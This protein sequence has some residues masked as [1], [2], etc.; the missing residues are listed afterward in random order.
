VAPR[1]L[2]IGIQDFEK[3]R[4]GG[5]V[6]ADKTA[7]I[8]RLASRGQSYFLGR[9]R[10]FGKSLLVSAIK[11]YFQGKR[12]VFE[13]EPRLAIA[14]LEKEW[15]IHPVFHI[16]L[17][18]GPYRDMGSLEANLD[19][20]LRILE[21]RW[22]R[23]AGDTL[24]STRFFGLI[25]RACESFGEK[26]VVLV[27]EYDKPLLETMEDPGLNGE[28]RREL[29]GFYG[30]LKAADPWLRFVFL[31]GVTK[32]SQVSVF[33]DLNQ[34]R[35][36]SLLRDYADICG[37]TEEELRGN[38][39]PELHSLA[40]ENG[41]SFGEALDKMRKYYNGYHFCEQT[42]GVYNPFS[43]LN[44]LDSR[45]FNYYWFQTGTPTFL[46]NLLTKANF[47]L[48]R[49]S[50][51]AAIPRTAI[52][53]A[54]EGSPLSILYQSGYLTI[55][56]YDAE[57]GLY[58]L[59]FPNEEVEYG[60]LGALLPYYGPRPE[61]QDFFAGNFYTDLR[62]GDTDAFMARLGAFFS[63]IPYDLH[64]RTER[65]YQTVFYLVFR[66]LGQFARAEVRSAAGRSDAVVETR[67]RVYVFEFKLA[68]R[69]SVE[70]AL[71]QIED[72]GYLLPYRAG[73]KRLVKVGAVFDPAKRTIG[74][75]KAVEE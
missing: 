57:T 52:Y 40:E 20:N 65:Y 56:G 71:Q 28:I 73:G 67:D 39:D 72:K 49:L 4:S 35:D 37:I 24:P 9:P 61:E 44:T 8:Y 5:F 63:S 70:T 47:D 3:L 36:I 12:E 13:G 60:F 7:F 64:E 42:G 53:Q 26:V 11:A 48:P 66:L 58:T 32:F 15:K 41:L 62:R 55:K 30:M 69:G 22:G 14:D 34:L 25:R 59:G 19:A 54:P 16:D 2:P 23:D 45:S 6:Y 31:T 33:S 10:R 75:W 18:G 74:D 38:F 1:K 27:D 29:K 50:E 46:I 51:G 68:G 43:V 17:T 21:E